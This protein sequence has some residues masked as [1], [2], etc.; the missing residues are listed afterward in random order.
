MI[1]RLIFVQK[2]LDKKLN[3]LNKCKGLLVSRSEESKTEIVNQLRGIMEDLELI[4]EDAEYIEKTYE[5]IGKEECPVMKM[6][7][8]THQG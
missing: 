4:L 5:I 8:P 2:I 1:G 3:E 6:S 7:D